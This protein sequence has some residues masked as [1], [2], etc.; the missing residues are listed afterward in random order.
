MGDQSPCRPA[1]HRHQ[2]TESSTNPGNG[3]PAPGVSHQGV[4]P[5]C[6]QAS[7]RPHR[8]RDQREAFRPQKQQIAQHGPSTG[9]TSPTP[10][11]PVEGPVVVDRLAFTSPSGEVRPQGS[12]VEASAERS[13]GTVE[14]PGQPSHEPGAA[15]EDIQFL[16]SRPF[17]T[18]RAHY[19][20]TSSRSC[21]TFELARN[22]R[23]DSAL[24][25]ILGILAGLQACAAGCSLASDR[26]FGTPGRRPCARRIT[27]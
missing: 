11:K 3:Q 15:P 6:P 23:L 18:S 17:A 5:G 4:R 20:D 19:A 14:R 26:L 16:T 13:G 1:V 25:T 2:L 7:R 24:T 22:W 9:C 10:S 12:L 8:R 21:L 27:P